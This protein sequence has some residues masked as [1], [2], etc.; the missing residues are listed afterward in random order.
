LAITGLRWET[1]PSLIIVALGGAAVAA[2]WRGVARRLIA[3]L[4]LFNGAFLMGWLAPRPSHRF[5]PDQRSG[6]NRVLS[7]AEKASERRWPNR[8]A[9]ILSFRY[10]AL[11]HVNAIAVSP[12]SLAPSR[13]EEGRM[14]RSYMMARSVVTPPPE[15]RSRYRQS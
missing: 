10:P 5:G 15:G 4:F 14:R 11:I 12:D 2:R 13:V 1:V 3:P 8:T 7:H 9:R 6:G